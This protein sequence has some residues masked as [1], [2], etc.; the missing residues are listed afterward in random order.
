MKKIKCIIKL[1]YVINHIIFNFFI[2]L[3]FLI[4]QIIKVDIKSQTLQTFGDGPAPWF[5]LGPAPWMVG[6]IWDFG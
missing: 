1:L 5:G 6:V 4:K 2:T 3:I